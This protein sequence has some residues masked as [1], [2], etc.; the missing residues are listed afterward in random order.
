[1][2]R[3]Y[4][5]SVVLGD[6]K[7]LVETWKTIVDEFFLRDE[8]IVDAA[9]LS[10]ASSNSGSS[11]RVSDGEDDE[12]RRLFHRETIHFAET[13]AA[14]GA[15]AVTA[16]ASKTLPH[17]QVMLLSG[18]TAQPWTR[19]SWAS[20]ATTT[21]A[22][23]TANPWES[24]SSSKA[25]TTAGS[26]TVGAA[27][28]TTTTTT[29]PVPAVH[30]IAT[31]TTAMSTYP[32]AA[33]SP[34]STTLHQPAAVAFVPPHRSSRDGRTT[35]NTPTTPNIPTPTAEVSF[36]P[37]TSSH[38]PIVDHHLFRDLHRLDMA[39]THHE[40]QLIRLRTS[41]QT[42]G[43][44]LKDLTRVSQ[45]FATHL[46]TMGLRKRMYQGIYAILR[47]RVMV[48]LIFW[49]SLSL[50]GFELNKRSEDI[51]WGVDFLWKT[52]Q[53]F[54]KRRIAKPTWS[55]VNDV[56]LNQRTKI[57]DVRALS[58]AQRS[59]RAMLYDFL[60]QHKYV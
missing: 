34:P 46:Q 24:H 38:F 36:T 49:T 39:L 29:R 27:G 59:L 8:A 33:T 7:R 15:A 54:V 1:M 37:T 41:W 14:A 6:T 53:R 42:S 43:V 5:A 60:L 30:D 13:A 12:V 28:T 50:A 22:G 40:R 31:A 20:T 11:G 56:I 48:S 25:A 19:P 17:P 51:S 26:A 44:I 45:T 3:Y 32:W 58:D 57:T 47:V 4:I 23:T 16:A 10:L 9:D 2:Y 55:I 21:A 52:S 18:G 35:T